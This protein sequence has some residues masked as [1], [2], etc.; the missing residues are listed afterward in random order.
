VPTLSHV[1]LKVAIAFPSPRP[2]AADRAAMPQYILSALF[3]KSHN[4]SRPC[5][6]ASNTPRTI[7]L[8]ALS[9]P[10]PCRQ[11]SRP[12]PQLL[13]PTRLKSAPLTRK[14][15]RSD[16]SY[17]RLSLHKD[18]KRA[19]WFQGPPSFAAKLREPT[20]HRL[21]RCHRG[22][23]AVSGGMRRRKGALKVEEP[24]GLYAT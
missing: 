4:I 15:G 18:L 9:Y 3:V 22:L 23:L 24:P 8:V 14:R 13:A 10:Q 21:W 12:R 19:D 16:T 5:D 1:Q 17:P 2:K 6:R 11:P 20:I 7:R